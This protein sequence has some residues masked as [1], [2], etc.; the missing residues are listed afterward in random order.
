ME[1]DQNAQNRQNCWDY[2]DTCTLPTH[3]EKN[4]PNDEHACL[5]LKS[6]VINNNVGR[7]RT[8]ELKSISADVDFVV[9]Q[10]HNMPCDHSR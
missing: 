3:V 9:S 1:S 4:D 7:L 10:R 2:S 5:L 8:H 6:V